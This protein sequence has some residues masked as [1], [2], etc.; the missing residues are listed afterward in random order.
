MNEYRRLFWFLF[1]LAFLI[2]AN[3]CTSSR[4]IPINEEIEREGSEI[5]KDSG[6]S[7]KGYQLE[8]G[9]EGGYDGR[10]RLAAQDSLVFWI[11]KYVEGHVESGEYVPE[12]RTCVPGPVYPLDT[13]KAL[14]VVMG[15]AGKT[16][17]AIILFPVVFTVV[18]AAV[19]VAS[20]GGNWY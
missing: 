2:T 15:S 5:H 16:V 6:Q 11:D 13:V 8:D 12:S 19:T 14:K 18:I 7:I 3:G 17:G 10:V 20:N 1:L 9:T 4:W